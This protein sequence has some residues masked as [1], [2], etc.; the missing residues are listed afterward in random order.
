[1]AKLDGFESCDDSRTVKRLLDGME[2]NGG[3]LCVGYMTRKKKL[4]KVRIGV[5][6]VMFEKLKDRL[7]RKGTIPV[8]SMRTGMKENTLPVDEY[9]C[10]MA[11]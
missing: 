1:M 11:L 10:I 6:L 4:G 5:L 9:F 8:S 2:F 3:R 7:M